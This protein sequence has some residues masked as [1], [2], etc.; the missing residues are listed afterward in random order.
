MIFH[1]GSNMSISGLGTIIRTDK[2]GLTYINIDSGVGAYEFVYE[3]CPTISKIGFYMARFS[4]LPAPTMTSFKQC[5]FSGGDNTFSSGDLLEVD[6][7]EASVKLNDKD[8]PSLGDISNDWSNFYLDR[9]T[10]NIYVQWSDW[11]TQS[12]TVTMKYRKRW[13]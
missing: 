3:D 5:T 7:T 11:V 12:P 9:G 6:C 4:S 1:N 10:N 8:E 2:D 13:L